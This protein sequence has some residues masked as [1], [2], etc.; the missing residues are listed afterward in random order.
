[1]SSGVEY[2]ISFLES[3]YSPRNDGASAEVYGPSAAARCASRAS[4]YCRSR[5]ACAARMS[6]ASLRSWARYDARV[7][8]GWG[9]AL[10]CE[11]MSYEVGSGLSGPVHC[12]ADQGSAIAKNG[13]ST[14]A[15]FI[16]FDVNVVVNQVRSA[17]GYPVDKA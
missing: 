4:R 14:Y 16:G 11:P 12:T 9:S 5:S 6:S 8:L 17:L 15:A 10:V 3:S 7:D 13:S 2:G 1:M